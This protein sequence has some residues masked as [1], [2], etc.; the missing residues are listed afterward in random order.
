MRLLRKKKLSGDKS[1]THKVDDL[2]TNC[3][4]GETGR[5]STQFTLHSR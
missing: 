1:K 4:N 2:R 3:T 5:L